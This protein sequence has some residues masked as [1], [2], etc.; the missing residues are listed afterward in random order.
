MDENVEKYE[1]QREHIAAKVITETELTINEDDEVSKY[2]GRLEKVFDTSRT[3]SRRLV[4]GEM[5]LYQNS[6]GKTEEIDYARFNQIT[7]PSPK[8]A[9]HESKSQSSP[10]SQGLSLIDEEE[11]YQINVPEPIGLSIEELLPYQAVDSEQTRNAFDVTVI[12][13]TYDDMSTVRFKVEDA[14]SG[15]MRAPAEFLQPCFESVDENNVE[16]C[17]VQNDDELWAHTSRVA[18]DEGSVSMP[19]SKNTIFQAGPS[20]HGLETLD[21]QAKRPDSQAMFAR[22]D[23]NNILET[24]EGIKLN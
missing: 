5:M 10:S 21:S 7:V 3:K 8:F 9:L 22:M 23:L 18:E 13:E 15:T 11:I 17:E 12:H 4:D 24:E 1:M 19:N 20:R 2:T 16:E 14:I 6:C